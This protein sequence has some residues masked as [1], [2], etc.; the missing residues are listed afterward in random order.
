MLNKMNKS[1]KFAVLVTAILVAFWLSSTSIGPR[2]FVNITGPDPGETRGE[3]RSIRGVYLHSRAVSVENTDNWVEKLKRYD[4]NGVVIN[5]KNVSGEVTYSSEVPTAREL[6]SVTGRLELKE[7]LSR[8]HRE[9][10]YVIARLTCFK[11]PAMAARCCGG[12]EWVD[13]E[14]RRA[15]RYNIQLAKEVA[16]MGFDE[17]QLDYI[18]YSDGPGK[19][20]G[21]YADRSEVIAGF[22]ERLREEISPRVKLSLDVYGRTI[23]NW[24]SK[25][26]DPI[27]Q[28]LDYLSE[29][30]EILS[31]MIYPSHYSN[32]DLVTQPKK[33]VD[34][35][36]TVG[37]KRLS[38]H[39]R[40]FIQGFDRAVPWNMGLVEYIRE[41]LRALAEHEK[42]GFL[43]W[44]PRSDYGAL[45]E[46][47]ADG[48]KV[49]S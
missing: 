49:G 46:A 12:G 26:I 24:N 7:I 29:H 11:D 2:T 16:R 35:A 20:G 19:I 40:P 6:G 33:L 3:T 34:K 32:P 1:T 41:E 47:V 37:G 36:L 25:N 18:R 13:P 14:D 38:T 44:N 27:G 45:W 17:I 4:F 30:A 28:N 22:V 31:P 15:Q 42:E 48:W 39:I 9:G 43:V 10:I 23:W 21:E 8:F 5:V